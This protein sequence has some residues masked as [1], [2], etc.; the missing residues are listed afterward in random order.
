MRAVNRPAAAQALERQFA[1]RGSI[2]LALDEVIVP[3]DEVGDFAGRSPYQGAQRKLGSDTVVSP[4]GGAAQY[5]G[6]LITPGAG[7][8]LV[9]EALWA[10]FAS[11]QQQHLKL[12]RPVDVAAVNVT[13]ASQAIAR[14]DGRM[15]ATGFIEQISATY[16]LFDHTTLVIGG[17][18]G[19]WRTVANWTGAYP[20]LP[21]GIVLDGTDPAG[22]ISLAIMRDALNTDMRAG[23]ALVEYPQ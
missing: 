14:I 21:R 19:S 7:A 5:S 22:P 9:V 3:T 20:G 16:S 10:P 2:G 12:F 1:L 15:R 13:S 11:H 18:I 23:F 6:V 4:A 8:V 17:A